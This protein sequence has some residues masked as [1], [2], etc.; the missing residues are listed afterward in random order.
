[1]GS[2]IGWKIRGS[3]PTVSTDPSPRP[4]SL[5]EEEVWGLLE[6]VDDPELGVPITDLGL[7][8]SVDVDEGG[9][10]I[11]MT[12]TTPICPLGEYLKDRVREVLEGQ[13][14]T[15]DLTHAPLWSPEMMNAAARR[16]LGWD[17]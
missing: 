4:P 6:V 15:V 2:V 14:V 5:S 1:M 11:V 17:C 7:V 13:S 16:R 8:Y 9:I 12:T 10:R 3:R